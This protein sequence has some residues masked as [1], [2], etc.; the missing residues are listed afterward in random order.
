VTLKVKIVIAVG[1]YRL[2]GF[3]GLQVMSG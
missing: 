2:E 1:G 3:L